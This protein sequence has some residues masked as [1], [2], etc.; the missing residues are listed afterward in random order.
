[1]SIVMKNKHRYLQFIIVD[2][3]EYNEASVTIM[4]YLAATVLK[5]ISKL[6]IKKLNRFYCSPFMNALQRFF[7]IHFLSG[8]TINGKLMRDQ[9]FRIQL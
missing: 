2:K 6:N 9:M 1:M 5:Q 8:C 7:C 4:D 3:Y